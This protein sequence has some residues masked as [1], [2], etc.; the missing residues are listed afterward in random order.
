M[1]LDKSTENSADMNIRPSH[2]GGERWMGFQTETTP[3][4]EESMTLLER[5]P[6][7]TPEAQIAAVDRLVRNPSEAI[8]MQA[9]QIGSQ[10]YADEQLVAY[11]RNETD[12]VLR[13]AG[14][15]M[16]KMRGPEALPLAVLLL[17]DSA[18]D[19]V[20]QAVVVLDH[21]KDPRALEP[22][23]PLLRHKDP[24]I[25][26]AVI[27]G[28]GH[29]GDGRVV[30][31]LIPFLQS[32]MWEQMAAVQALGDLRSAAAVPTLRNLLNDPMLAQFAIES[33]ARIGGPGAFEALAVHWVAYHERLEAET[34]LGFLAHVIEGL[35][36]D[37]TEVPGLRACIAAFLKDSNANIRKHAAACL[38]GLGK[39]PEDLAA[40]QILSDSSGQGALP[41]CLSRR[42]DL[43]RELLAS[44]GMLR[45]W[46]ITLAARFPRSCS[47]H[48]LI[49]AMESIDLQEP[50]QPLIDALIRW[51]D[52]MLAPTI[53]DLFIRT[54]GSRRRALTPLM[55]QNK[56]H[57]AAL[58]KK[59]VTIDRQTRLT[60]LALAGES[61]A[62]ISS[63]ILSL[64]DTARQSVLSQLA[65]CKPV[66]ELL[67][68]ETWLTEQPESYGSI[69]AEVAVKSGL[70]RL[71]EPLRELLRKYPAPE[72]I[73]VLSEFKDSKTID[74]LLELL[75][76]ECD[77]EIGV[78]TL[79]T[80]AQFGGKAVQNVLREMIRGSDPRMVRAA[81]KGLSRCGSREDAS[82]FREA[83][84]S[85]D[86]HVRLACA[87]AFGRFF[88]MEN[89]I[90][91]IQ[92]SADPVCVVAQRVHGLL[93]VHGDAQWSTKLATG[94]K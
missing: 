30:R 40:I 93:A 15:Q 22:M 13:N 20:L 23:R 83:I 63:G 26:Q 60:L 29:C 89:R 74:C 9:L 73:R 54:D 52:P 8:R 3:T 85:E 2:D 7:M 76:Q 84:R 4:W 1:Y 6:A 42:G 48:D 43:V 80:L 17:E 55:K 47:I 58:V 31:D 75:H 41:V 90:A 16:L 28:L 33:L 67:P 65:D 71:L 59:N 77:P 38:L 64:S 14:V 37:P 36:S 68:W 91:L 35:Q 86:W 57:L 18:P 82:L 50:F 69:A 53:L 49:K 5:F 51:N 10:I 92:L 32:D 62:E 70:H 61:P 45:H 44:P 56:D 25:R 24:N 94:E 39:G 81:Y 88:S 19:V 78:V 21:L 11:L 46:G 72:F 87:E 27:V 66:M 79:E 34:K 12:D